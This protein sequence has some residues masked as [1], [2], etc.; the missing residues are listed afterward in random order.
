MNVLNRNSNKKQKKTFFDKGPCPFHLKK[1]FIAIYD[2]FETT[3]FK[4]S[5]TFFIRSVNRLISEVGL[6]V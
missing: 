1:R 6:H 4:L 2:K 5:Y 3:G